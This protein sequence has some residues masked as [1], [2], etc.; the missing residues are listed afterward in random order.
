[1]YHAVIMSGGAGSRLWPL[2]RQALPKQFLRLTTEEP[3]LAETVARLERTVPIERIWVVTGRRYAAMVRQ[4]L[5]RLPA[6]NVIAEPIAR[7]TTGAV[8]LAAARLLRRDPDAVFSVLP[9]DHLMHNLDDFDRALALAA[10]LAGNGATVCIG[11][12]PRYPETGYGYIERGSQVRS[13]DGVAAFDVKRFVEKPDLA[14]A[15]EYLRAGTFL[16]N[17]GIFTWRAA[18]LRDLLAEHLPGSVE[19]FEATERQLDS[20]PDAA[21]A[22]FAQLPNLSVDYAVLEK[23]EDRQ[24]VEADLG[25]VDIGDWA[26]VHAAT[27]A[28]DARDNVLPE[29]CI[30]IDVEGSYVQSTG[31]KL[32]AA[33]GVRDLVVID[34]EDVLLICAR[35]R[36]Q[37]VKRAVD[38][39]RARGLEA[40]L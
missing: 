9:S 7:N 19:L 15:T 35:D 34:T 39:A 8:G 20:D 3:L 10:E 4:L 22:T 29:Q 12:T 25:W 33:I 23:A 21:L 32:I 27:A 6:E 31:S 18:R 5:P 36:T 24:V 16:W 40:R 30:A 28:K 37:D 13:A 17:A 2:T 26:A 1:M 38:E 11:V 14:R